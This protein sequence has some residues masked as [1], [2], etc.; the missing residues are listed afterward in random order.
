MANPKK[1]KT[2]S[3]THKGRSHLALKK[4]VL[5]KCSK[6]GKAVKPHT[7]CVSCGYYNGKEVLKIKLK[8][9]KKK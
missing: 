5:N 3:S 1:R 9:A 6:C 2:H 4:I 7:V 8:T